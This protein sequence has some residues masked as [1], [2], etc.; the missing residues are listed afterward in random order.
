MDPAIITVLII[1]I[2][3]AAMLVF[4]IVRIDIVALVC[5]L[6]LG[7]TGVLTPQEALSGFSSNAVIAM[8]A[9]MILG[10]GIAKT[11]I[12]D[13]F[14][15]AVLKKVGVNRKRVIGLM[16]LSV[17]MLSGF[18][19]NI[20][21]AALFLPG[22]L[23]ISRKGKIPASVLI[24]PIGF[25]AILG[26]T[27]SMVGSGPLILINDLL[28]NA[29]LEP[30]RLFSVTPVGLLLL[31]FG[32]GFFLLFGKFVL[33]Y[34]EASGKIVSEQEKL[35]NTLHLPYSI[36]HYI[37]SKNSPLIG[38]TTEQ[39]GVWD[40]FKLNIL[41]IS[42]GRGVEYAPWRE[43][44]F[45][46]GQEL[47]LLGDEENVENFASEFKLELE[48]R[49]ARFASLTD[50]D[51]SGFAEVIM[52]PRSEMIG[53]TIRKYSLRKSHAVEPVML[54]SKGEEIRG[55]FS[56]HEVVSGDTIIVHG[57]WDKIN[58]LKS[59]KNFL[60]AT[61]F[62]LEKKDKSKTWIA[63]LCF[64]AAIGLA[65][66][67]FPISIAFFTGAIAMV[68]MRVLDIQEAYQSIE[69]KV[70]FLIAGLIPLGIAMQ[71]TGT[72][73]FLAEQIMTLIQGK[74]PIFLVL[75]VAVLST[76]FSLFMSNVGA[77]VVLAPLVMNMA[78]IGG[79]VSASE[80]NLCIFD[81]LFARIGASDNLYDGKSTFMVE[82]LETANIINNATGNSFVIMDEIGRGTSTFDGLSIA[83]SVTKHI[84]KN[85]KAK[86]IFATH[87]HE[88]TSLSDKYQ[89]IKNMN[90]AVLEDSNRIRFT[91]KVIPGFAQKSYGIHVAEI[92][93]L[94]HSL[95]SDA[96]NIL[97]TL[98]EE[99]LSIHKKK[100]SGIKQLSLF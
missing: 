50:P 76:L 59:S 46:A 27:L 96:K 91:Y 81:K 72:A 48:E 64:A 82:M 23:N 25:A 45:E 98:E 71:K 56:D 99:D 6:A 12:M 26:G 10:H 38:K 84:Y 90:V 42:R 66:A 33:P 94:P 74:H 19:Q 29:D 63:V 68:L 14:S 9:V 13:Q 62:V 11:G 49:S 2:A 97:N 80:A 86:S 85:I 21:A 87:Y 73:A 51:K 58:D 31:L 17:G 4:E 41:G 34:S 8:M 79:F 24:M 32:I 35:I 93:G 70:V 40:K 1:L 100:S 54:F 83:A 15:R 95:I 5:M 60:V 20:G 69:G 77:I 7:W 18:I 53:Q 65:L 39:T 89:G 67:G 55:D 36:R 37:I 43:T 52:P 88:L 28:R 3:T 78:Q 92:A 47:A 75:A 44:Q 22:I 16:S 57:L 30:Y 61:P